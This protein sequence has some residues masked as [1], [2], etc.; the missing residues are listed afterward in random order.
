MKERLLGA[1]K[2]IA[3]RLRQ[4]EPPMLGWWWLAVL[5]GAS[6]ALYYPVGMALVHT[7]DDDPAFVAAPPPPGASRGAAMAAGLILR[8]VDERRW[9]PNDPFFQPSSALDNMPAFQQGIVGAVGS[10]VYEMSLRLARPSAGEAL[11]GDVERAAGLLKYPGNVWMFD[12]STS[13]APVASSEK[14]YR[15]AARA[16]L[17]YNARLAAGQAHFE[18]DPG[19]LALLLAHIAQDL[20]RVGADL[21]TQVDGAFWG[22]FD[23]DADESFYAAK[24]RLYA[25]S[26]L[27]AELGADLSAPLAQ[28]NLGGAWRQMIESL[29]AAAALDPLLVIN[30][31]PDSLLMPSHLAAEGFY[32]G[33]A[34]ARLA[35]IADALAK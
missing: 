18:T 19:A 11:D 21:G 6:V 33:R 9:T 20:E 24:G 1:L 22:P 16:L 4:S 7:I 14:Q 35:E 32:A 12:P 5:G 8:E 15:A 34:R 10:F 2:D 17:N 30:G 3:T 26:R 25:Y 29:A 31:G 27:L 23:T 28:R 13:W